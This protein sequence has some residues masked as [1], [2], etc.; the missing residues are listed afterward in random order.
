VSGVERTDADGFSAERQSDFLSHLANRFF[1][2]ELQRVGQEG[3]EDRL[4]RIAGRCKEHSLF[5]STGLC[6]EGSL[7]IKMACEKAPSSGGT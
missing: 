7:P 3:Q 1:F 5:A 6:K 4:I 2:N